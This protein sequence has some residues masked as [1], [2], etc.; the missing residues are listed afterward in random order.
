[1]NEGHWSL[2]RTVSAIVFFTD[3]RAALSQ[4]P[5]FSKSPFVNLHRIDLGREIFGASDSYSA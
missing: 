1:M 2:F 3:V 5:Q 4:E